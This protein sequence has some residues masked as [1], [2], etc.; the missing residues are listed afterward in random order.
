[1]FL[2]LISIFMLSFALVSC[3]NKTPEKEERQ[4]L[5]IKTVQ[6]SRPAPIVPKSDVLILKD[7]K[8]IVVSKETA[9]E[10]L[11]DGL[12]YF[13]LD[14]EQYENLSVNNSMIRVVIQQK[15]AV[16]RSYESYFK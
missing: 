4:P 6:I 8:W 16:I 12:A 5:E 2:R 15:D 7:V 14:A 11:K 1:M 3:G 13:A 9:S 10:K